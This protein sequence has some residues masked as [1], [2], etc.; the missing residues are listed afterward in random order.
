MDLS[1]PLAGAASIDRRRMTLRDGREWVA[2]AWSR[3]R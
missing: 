2:D 1:S 3:R